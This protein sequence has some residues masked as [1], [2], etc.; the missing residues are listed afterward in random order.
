MTDIKRYLRCDR[1]AFKPQRII[2]FGSH[3]YGQPNE[4]SDVDVLVVMPKSEAR[5]AGHGGENP[6]EGARGLSRGHAGAWRG[7]RGAAVRQKTCS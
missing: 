7:R 1:A 6:A 5:E 2:L 3:A 4:D